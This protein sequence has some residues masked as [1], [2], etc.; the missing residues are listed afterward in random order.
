MLS[1]LQQLAGAVRRFATEEDLEAVE[2]ANSVEFIHTQTGMTRERFREV[3]GEF[4]PE[5]VRRLCIL[6][7]KKHPGTPG[8]WQKLAE[9]TEAVR[10]QLF[11]Q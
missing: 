6:A 8:E 11:Q 9:E 7:G 1:K 2:A 4:D 10:T 5:T 3:F